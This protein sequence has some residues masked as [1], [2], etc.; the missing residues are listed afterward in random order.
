[1]KA[2]SSTDVIANLSWRAAIKKFDPSR[3]I[4]GDTWKALEHAMVLAPSSYGLQP[5]RFLVVENPKTREALR[6]VSWNQTQITDASHLVVLCRRVNVTPEDVQKYVDAIV[7][8]RH[9]PAAAL[10][11]LKGMMLGSI[12]NPASLGGGSMEAWTS[13]QVYIALGFFLSSAA[14]MGVD[15]CPMEGFDPVKYDEILGLRAQGYAATVI[16]TAGYR[17]SDDPYSSAAKVRFPV[18]QVVKHV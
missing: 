6:V 4:A 14:M 16:V 17:A 5:W 8:I 7:A 12:S 13:R 18:E 15:A 11:G 3:K 10:D 2:V 1:M 9:V